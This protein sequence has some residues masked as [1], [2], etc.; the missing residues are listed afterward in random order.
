MTELD[1]AHGESVARAKA[2]MLEGIVPLV[3]DGT[4]SYC[5]PSA[6][7]PGRAHLVW[8]PLAVD[9]TRSG[10]ACSCRAGVAHAFCWHRARVQM[11]L[12]LE[13]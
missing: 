12:G 8:A 6:S 7:Q 9:E 2:R 11:F 13:D 10:W 1:T 5:V 3:L 4:G